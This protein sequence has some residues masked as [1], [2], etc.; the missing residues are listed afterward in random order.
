M[1]NSELPNSSQRQIAIRQ[2]IQFSRLGIFWLVLILSISFYL[3][4]KN[5]LNLDWLLPIYGILGLAFFQQILLIGYSEKLK[6]SFIL[7]SFIIDTLFISFFIYYSGSNQSFFMFLHLVNILLAGFYF[8]TMGAFIVALTASLSLTVSLIFSDISETQNIIFVLGLNHISFYVVAALSGFLSSQL[9]DTRIELVNTEKLNQEML[10]HLP[11][12]LLTVQNDGK[13]IIG[14][15]SL[16]KILGIV[17]LPL[18]I[19]DLIQIDWNEVIHFLN[20]ENKDFHREMQYNSPGRDVQTIKIEVSQFQTDELTEMVQLVLISDMTEVRKLEYRM[21]QSE[22]LA[23]IGGLAAGIA[24][25][26]RNPLAGISGSIEM[27]SQN[28]QTDD[29]KK[30][31]KIVLREI[32]R[33]NNLITEFLDFAKPETP[34]SEMVN[35]SQIVQESVASMKLNQQLNQKTVQNIF[36]D[37]DVFILGKAD[38]LKQAVLNFLINSY[39]AMQNTENPQL[40]VFLLNK[41]DKVELK[42]IDN[43]CGMKEETRKRMFEP[44][45]TTKPKGTGLGLAIT[46]KILENHQVR[47]FVQ[48]ELGQGTEVA[49]TFPIVKN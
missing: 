39:Q 14:N 25:E 43:G 16:N 34:P 17:E 26:I 46:H 47:I 1:L 15:P 5:F 8:Q 11:I 31:M 35:L 19:T 12:G 42:I 33:L 20:N 44:F 41:N 23:A 3:L 37:K 9:R 18:L 30:L 40:S 32:D 7:V 27:L 45:H 29:D 28:T 13:L 6:E 49:L 22:K 4:Q 21:R 38:K 24:H 48:S 2:L 10:D 36:I